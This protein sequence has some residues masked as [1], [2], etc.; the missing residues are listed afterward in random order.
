[1]DPLLLPIPGTVQEIDRLRRAIPIIAGRNNPVIIEGEIESLNEVVART[2]HLASSR[3]CRVFLSVESKADLNM[4]GRNVDL[5]FSK[6]LR[7]G[8]LFLK[9]FWSMSEGQRE[10][11]LCLASRFNVRLLFST[12]SLSEEVRIRRITPEEILTLNPFLVSLNR[13]IGEDIAI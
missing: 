1:M 9:D 2:V 4:L 5:F 11:V 13:G 3:S 8:S 10:N 7:G 12:W 6:W